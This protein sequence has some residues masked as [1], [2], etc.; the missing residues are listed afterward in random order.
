MAV[1]PGDRFA[2]E[3]HVRARVEF[4]LAAEL[5][6]RD[7]TRLR[8]DD[9]V[10]VYELVGRVVGRNRLLELRS[11]RIRQGSKTTW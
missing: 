7:R 4:E 2:V 6:R 1:M 3:S 9:Q 8:V 11:A 5:A 10:W